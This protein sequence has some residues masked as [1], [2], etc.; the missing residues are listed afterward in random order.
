[1]DGVTGRD[2]VLLR[3]V[4]VGQRTDEAAQHLRDPPRALDRPEEP[5]VPFHLGREVL[6]RPVG[7]VLVED[8]LR[9][10]TDDL[11]VRS[12]GCLAGHGSP[13]SSRTCEPSQVHEYVARSSLLALRA[14]LVQLSRSLAF[15]SHV[16]T[17]VPCPPTSLPPS[18]PPP[19]CPRTDPPTFGLQSTNRP[20]NTGPSP[21]RCP[22]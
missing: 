12:D 2:H 18:P 3:R 15:A 16:T 21:D 22:A 9:V 4:Q 13:P 10:L 20:L 17:V 1:G 7:L 8:P 11:G 19:G 6:G 5:S 14:P